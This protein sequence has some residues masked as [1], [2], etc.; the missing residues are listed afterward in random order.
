MQISHEIPLCLLEKSKSF[1]DYDYC[2]TAFLDKYP[3][4]KEFFT[5]SSKEGRFII[6]DNSLHEGFKTT[7]EIFIKYINKIKPDIFIVPDVWN[8]RHDTY[9]NAKYWMNT[10]KASLPEKTELMAVVQGST[11]A[12]CYTLYI[13]LLQLGYKHIAI[14]YSSKMYPKI[15]PHKNI[16]VSRMMGRILFINRL[17][18][19]NLV[20]E[21]I[22]HHL[23]GC[24]VVDEF[25]YYRGYDFI[26]SIDTSNPI[27]LGALNLKYGDKVDITWKSATTIESILEEELTESQLKCVDFNVK[28]FKK[29]VNGKN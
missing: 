26:K 18:E 27:V 29:L 28:Y 15:F 8:D 7:D 20:N 6:M 1:N 17:V 11:F 12:D 25:K 10:I 13:D 4:Y 9:K 3:K 24:S 16:N 22:Y 19:M 23:L 5:K 14:N 2:L 21:N